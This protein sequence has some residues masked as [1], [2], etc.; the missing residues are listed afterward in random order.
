MNKELVI[1]NYSDNAQA[2]IE[3]FE[4]EL[5]RITLQ[6]D[7]K[8]VEANEEYNNKISAIRAQFDIDLREARNRYNNA[9]RMDLVYLLQEIV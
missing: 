8:Y 2:L 3:A 7:K 4:N 9:S 5:A 1:S 6:T